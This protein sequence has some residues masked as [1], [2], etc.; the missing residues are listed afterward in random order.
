MVFGS[1]LRSWGLFWILMWIISLTFG[2]PKREFSHLVNLFSPPPSPF[3]EY[4]CDSLKFQTGIFL[5]LSIRIA[6]NFHVNHWFRQTS[7][8]LEYWEVLVHGHV[9]CQGYAWHKS[10]WDGGGASALWQQKWW[11]FNIQITV[12]D[13]CANQWRSYGCVCVCRHISL[14]DPEL[15]WKWPL[16][17]TFRAICKA[18]EPALQA[19]DGSRGKGEG[20]YY[21]GAWR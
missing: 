7:K 1:L 11:I 2:L 21:T 3:I 14:Q 9:V 15:L 13:Y 10:V 5:Y 8:A 6:L 12:P 18:S 16:P 19:V 20:L 4:S 17:L